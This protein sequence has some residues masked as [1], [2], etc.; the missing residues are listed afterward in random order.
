MLPSRIASNSLLGQMREPM[1]T[2]S[3]LFPFNGMDGVKFSNNEAKIDVP[4]F[5]S[6]NLEVF[7]DKGYLTVK[8]DRDTRKLNK[9][10]Y[11]GN[12]ADISKV[13]VKDGVLTV[14]LDNGQQTN[15]SVPIEEG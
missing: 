7:F 15:Q 2:Y 4:G 9:T 1:F 6:D 12:N 14:K 3:E 8:G 5:N 13:Y 11:V 10:V